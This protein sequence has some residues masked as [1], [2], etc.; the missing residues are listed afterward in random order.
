VS[1]LRYLTLLGALLLPSNAVAQSSPLPLPAIT[2]DLPRGQYT[3]YIAREAR[4]IVGTLRCRSDLPPRT[5]LL[6]VY[7]GSSV[8]IGPVSVFLSVDEAVLDQRG[9]VTAVWFGV[10]VLSRT[11]GPAL[12]VRPRYVLTMP[13]GEA[14]RAG[15]APGVRVT[16][17]RSGPLLQP[18]R[19]IRPLVLPCPSPSPPIPVPT[20]SGVR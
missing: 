7:D 16:L 10:P 14:S 18:L 12:F 17:P 11:A 2:L 8:A 3:A 19:Q 1:T 6:S 5:M 9:V 4:H 15:L 20:E 13:A